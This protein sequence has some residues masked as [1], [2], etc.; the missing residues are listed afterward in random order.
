VRTRAVGAVGTVE[1]TVGTVAHSARKRGHVRTYL[2]QCGEVTYG[3]VMHL[4]GTV[5]AAAG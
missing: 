5:A 2:Q 4:L 3:S 1:T